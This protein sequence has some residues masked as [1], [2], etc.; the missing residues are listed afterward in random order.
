MALDIMNMLNPDVAPAQQNISQQLDLAKM[1]RQQSF[2][3]PASQMVSGYYVPPSITQNLSRLMQGYAAGQ[4]QKNANEQTRSL[5]QSQSQF[6]LN[7]LRGD[8]PS[9]P[10][11]PA[12]PDSSTQNTP[13]ITGDQVMSATGGGVNA[14]QDSNA[15]IV[16]Q[17]NPMFDPNQ[18]Q[19]ASTQTPQSQNSSPS[20]FGGF[21]PKGMPSSQRMLA[22]MMSPEAYVG[23]TLK[24][25]EPTDTQKNDTYYGIGQP[26]AKQI[27]LNDKSP[28]IVKLYNA[29]Q[30]ALNSGNPE[31]A[32]LIDQAIGKANNIP[33]Q[34]GRP[35]GAMYDA[36]GNIVAAT[37]KFPD[38]SRPIIQD[39]K[40]VGVE[41]LAG[42]QG[43]NQQTSYGSEAGKEGYQPQPT[44]TP[45]SNGQPSKFVGQSISN[46]PQ[47]TPGSKEAMAG[48]GTANAARY[49]K[50][51]DSASGSPMRVNVL[52]NIINL[53]KAG[54]NTGPG[55]EWKQAVKGYVANTPVLGSVY[56]KLSSTDP[57]QEVAGFQ[58]LQK[59]TY[60][61]GLQ[62]WQSAGGTGTDAQMASFSHAN[63]N[64]KLFPTALQ[65][66]SQWAKAGEI[67]LQAKANAQ[68]NFMQREGNNPV[69]QNK[70]ESTWRQNFDPRIYQMQLMQPAE[71]AQFM[72]K[73]PDAST[74]KQK[75]IV[76]HNNGWV[77]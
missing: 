11:Q 58:E 75:V 32:D 30:A 47:F 55:E 71:R 7:A 45:I 59:F 51:V 17:P 19:Q 23:A 53:S 74:L 5:A 60:Q 18:P 36:K 70:F 34:A 52:D 73:Q 37:P 54:V 10:S 4:I 3:A 29:K 63:P 26:Q 50:T 39:G 42:A 6:L 65:G 14:L 62:A 76:A 43:I 44:Q 77:Q 13:N 35:G 28:D 40:I 12:Q 9:Q 56:A 66:I 48:M 69:A 16:G 27:Y 41:P 46:Q 72:A 24:Q 33:L 49:A 68:D 15:N 8:Q 64:D 22:M 57:K 21:G 38:N 61:N 20:T 31:S 25:Y 1:L 2:E 67:A